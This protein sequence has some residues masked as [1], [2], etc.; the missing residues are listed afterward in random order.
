M[1]H[2]LIGEIYQHQKTGGLYE[3]MGMAL[4]EST[5]ETVVIYRYLESQRVWVRLATEFFD[6]R[7]ELA[8]LIDLED[9][10]EWM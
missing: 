6:G 8:S 5:K 2:N 4:L 1:K 10:Q 3:F 9:E 7:F